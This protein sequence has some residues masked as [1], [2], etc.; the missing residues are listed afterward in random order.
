M[1]KRNPDDEWIAPFTKADARLYWKLNDI[2]AK[3]KPDAVPVRFQLLITSSRDPSLRG[4]NN[5]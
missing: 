4:R 5:S 3:F 1:K 2:P